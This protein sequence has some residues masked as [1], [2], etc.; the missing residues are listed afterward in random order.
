[1]VEAEAKIHEN[2]IAAIAKMFRKASF[3]GLLIQKALVA[4]DIVACRIDFGRAFG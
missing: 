4:M 1:M 2:S 3:C